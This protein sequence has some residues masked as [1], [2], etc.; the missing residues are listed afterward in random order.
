MLAVVMTTLIQPRP[1]DD[2]HYSRRNEAL[3]FG[4]DKNPYHPAVCS[5][6]LIASNAHTA[7]T[8]PT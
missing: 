8:P 1:S 5:R 3:S 2:I 6:H 7:N 4:N